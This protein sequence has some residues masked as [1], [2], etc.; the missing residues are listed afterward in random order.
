MLYVNKFLL[1]VK[2]ERVL[3]IFHDVQ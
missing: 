3:F 1:M 2:Q